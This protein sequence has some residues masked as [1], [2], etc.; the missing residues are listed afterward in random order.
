MS[1]SPLQTTGP[2]GDESC[3]YS[4]FN[5]Y[6]SEGDVSNLEDY[7]DQHHPEVELSV[8]SANNQVELVWPEGRQLETGNF[9]DLDQEV[10]QSGFGLSLSSE[11]DDSGIHVVFLDD[12]QSRLVKA[13][14]G[15]KACKNMSAACDTKAPAVVFESTRGES[16][17]PEEKGTVRGTVH[18]WDGDDTSIVSF[19][20]FPDQTSSEGSEKSGEG[21]HGAKYP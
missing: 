11:L 19:K 17:A 21:L 10:K 9:D 14:E 16:V 18:E 13:F 2:R 1:S 12:E 3:G 7:M 6:L 5:V 8:D 20:P 4:F 15:V